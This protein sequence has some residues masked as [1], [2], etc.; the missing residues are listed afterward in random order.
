MNNKQQILK[1]R[2]EMLF[3]EGFILKSL[4]PWQIAVRKRTFFTEGK[5]QEDEK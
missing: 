1:H 5:R 4:E 2:A 3:P